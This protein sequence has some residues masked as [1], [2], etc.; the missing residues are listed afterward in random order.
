MVIRNEDDAVGQAR[1]TVE[2]DQVVR[3]D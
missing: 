1:A 3:V 2:E